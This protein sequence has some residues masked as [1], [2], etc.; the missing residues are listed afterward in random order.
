MASDNLFIPFGDWDEADKKEAGRLPEGEYTLKVVDVEVTKIKAGPNEGTPG[1]VVWFKAINAPEG[2]EDTYIVD[3]FYTMKSTLWRFSGFLRAVGIKVTQNDMSLPY[4]Q[5]IGRRVTATLKDGEPF[6]DKIKSEVAQYAPVPKTAPMQG[7]GLTEETEL[8]GT[9]L[10][11]ERAD[12][13]LGDVK[14]GEMVSGYTA[15][16]PWALDN[17]ISL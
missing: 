15:E 14:D 4:K 16:D 10:S 8:V 17:E 6:K 1:L 13:I 9:P 5:L 3:R 2:L 12:A 7:S 11:P